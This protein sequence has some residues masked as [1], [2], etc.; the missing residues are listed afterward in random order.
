MQGSETGAHTTT[1]APLSGQPQ[2]GSGPKLVPMTGPSDRPA[3]ALTLRASHPLAPALDVLDVVFKGRLLP[4]MPLPP[5][6]FALLVAEAFDQ[7][8][9]CDDWAS[10]MRPDGDPR[11]HAALLAIWRD[12]VWPLFV[13]RYVGTQHPVTMAP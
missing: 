12:E 8:M 1:A 9:H 4:L 3:S 7:G 11:V 2:P 6:P 5:E 13:A 10:L